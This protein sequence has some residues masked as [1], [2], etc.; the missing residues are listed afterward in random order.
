MSRGMAYCWCGQVNS[1]ITLA[2]RRLKI[3]TTPAHHW[4]QW[5][6]PSKKLLPATAMVG[7]L[8]KALNF[9]GG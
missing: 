3:L 7:T 9:N 1:S 5:A 8:K 2:E 4:K 6:A